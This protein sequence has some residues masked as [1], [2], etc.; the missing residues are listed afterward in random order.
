[1]RPSRRLS[2]HPARAVPRFPPGAWSRSSAGAGARCSLAPLSWRPPLPSWRPPLSWRRPPLNWRRTPLLN[3]Q[4]IPLHGSR[5][6]LTRPAVAP[7]APGAPARPRPAA[8]AADQ[9]SL[10]T[11]ETVTFDGYVLSPDGVDA[12]P[13]PCATRIPDR[14]GISMNRPGEI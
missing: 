10:A 11:G 1:M 2:P 13:D 12:P 4:G 8:A 9:W 6:A 14:P 7:L 3:W 5:H